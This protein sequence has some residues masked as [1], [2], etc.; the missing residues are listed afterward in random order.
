MAR[1]PLRSDSPTTCYNEGRD[2]NPGARLHRP[3]ELGCDLLVKFSDFCKV[4]LRLVESTAK[5]YRRKM[6]RFLE[7]VGKPADEVMVEDVRGYLKP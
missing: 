7:T 2:L 4:D 5:D 3:D 1:D 6:R